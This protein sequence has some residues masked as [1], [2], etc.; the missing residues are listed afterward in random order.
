M[1]V[2]MMMIP[3]AFVLAGLAV[4]AFIRAVR[5]GQFDD[6]DTPP[7]RAVFDDDQPVP[8]TRSER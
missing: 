5:A 2:I 3:A 1:T 8:P 4:W 6:L 7:I